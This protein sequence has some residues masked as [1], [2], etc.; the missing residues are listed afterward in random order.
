MLETRLHRT[1]EY[2]VRLALQQVLLTLSC[3]EI[4]SGRSQAKHGPQAPLSSSHP[5][6]VAMLPCSK[7]QR[8]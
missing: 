7:W 4:K 5:T 2:S 8:W 6:S 1:A 3:G